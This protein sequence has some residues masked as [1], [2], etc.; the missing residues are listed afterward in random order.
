MIR[1]KHPIVLRRTRRASSGFM[2][3]GTPSRT[4]PAIITKPAQTVP[5]TMCRM[6]ATMISLNVVMRFTSTFRC[7]PSGIRHDV[8]V[9]GSRRSYSPISPGGASIDQGFAEQDTPAR[10]N[11]T[12]Q[13]ARLARRMPENA[14]CSVGEVPSVADSGARAGRPLRQVFDKRAKTPWR[15]SKLIVR[16]LCHSALNFVAEPVRAWG[17]E[18][19]REIPSCNYSGGA[20][21][22]RTRTKLRAMPQRTPGAAG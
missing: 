6:R 2:S 7:G 13:R 11:V 5:L 22:C 4:R 15:P 3:R 10:Q 19:S 16:A 8:S 12:M 1:E 21:L 14:A 9:I 18:M 17:R 20:R